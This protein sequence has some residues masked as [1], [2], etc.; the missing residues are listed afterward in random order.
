[1]QQSISVWVINLKKRPD[2]LENIG[3]KLNELGVLWERIDAIDGRICDDDLLNLSKK[4]GKIGNMSKSTRGCTA[5]HFKCWEAIL[6]SKS[7]YGIVLEDDVDLSNDF[8]ELISNTEWIP[9]N[10]KLIK[11]EKFAA[12]RHSKLLLGPKISST[13]NGTR[14]LR[15]MYSRHCGAGAY[16]FS[17]EGVKIALSWNKRLTVPIDHHLFNETVSQLSSKLEPL[18]LVPPVAWQSDE[19]G[20]GSDIDEDNY[21]AISKLKKIPRSIKRGYYEI[22]LWPYQL[23]VLL[24][25]KAKIIKVSKK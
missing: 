8:K 10:A 13:F 14:S 18:I 4:K 11:L 7:D 6:S 23:F 22:R 2:R 16:L 25:C 3:K 9:R 15:K 19:I 20:Q 21:K 12:N 17:K 24:S 1:M 5:S